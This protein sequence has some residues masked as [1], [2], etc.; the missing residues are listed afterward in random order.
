[1][2]ALPRIVPLGYG[3]AWVEGI[4]DDHDVIDTFNDE[5]GQD[6]GCFLKMV[7]TAIYLKLESSGVLD[8][9]L[10]PMRHLFPSWTNRGHLFILFSLSFLLRRNSKNVH[11]SYV[12]AD[13]QYQALDAGC[14]TSTST[15]AGRCN[16]KP[17]RRNWI[18]PSMVIF[19]SFN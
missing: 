2:V 1:M 6:P 8:I 4:I 7:K 10:G 14:W 5:Y 9:R 13:G 11:P 12:M 16:S 19:P 18:P 15:M 17:W 3:K